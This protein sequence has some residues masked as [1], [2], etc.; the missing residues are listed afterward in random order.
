MSET[1]GTVERTYRR[2]KEM[3]ASY[4]F[5]PD[6]RLNESEL[7]KRL[8]TSRTPL[9]EALNRLVAEGFLTFKSGKGFF[10]RSL[11]PAE[12]MDLYEARAAI[13][14][15]AAA[16][17][18]IRANAE[19]IA[20]LEK[21]LE[22]SKPDYK[23][24]TSPV[25]LVRLD[26]EFHT[27]LTALSGNAE[28]VRMLGNMN[29]RIHFVRLIDLKTLCERNGPDVVTTEPHKRI[30]E[31][32]KRRDPD[33]AR[34]EMAKHIERRLESITENVRNAFAELYTP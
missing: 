28:M 9:R 2:L 30:L 33:A 16:L 10:C 21:F 6:S 12:I 26:E 23:P 29:G 22:N 4:E 20:E 34:A 11:K 24:G 15:E 17:A 31:A 32:V 7:S 19:D 13:E 18:A 3:A 25:E 27:R 14:C 5:K 8:D 1:E